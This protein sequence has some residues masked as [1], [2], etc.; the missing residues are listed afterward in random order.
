MYANDAI[1][2]GANLAVSNKKTTN[3]KIH[4]NQDPLSFLNKI[5]YNF[6]KSI[7]SNN[8]AITGSSGKTSVKE[9]TGF[10]LKETVEDILFKKIHLIISL[11]FH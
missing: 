11:V 7:N 3:P 5:S 2:N 1:K 4:F 6:R 9:L 8:I 10:C